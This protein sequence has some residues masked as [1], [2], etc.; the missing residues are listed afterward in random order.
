MLAGVQDMCYPPEEIRTQLGEIKAQPATL[1][2]EEYAFQALRLLHFNGPAG[3]LHAQWIQWDNEQP[4]LLELL[5]KHAL[6]L[7]ELSRQRLFR[8]IV[9]IHIGM[10]RKK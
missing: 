7:D 6:E 2:T 1:N 9:M 8:H 4:E 3:W 10:L 5:T